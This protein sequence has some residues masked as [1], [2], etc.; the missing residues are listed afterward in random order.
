[1]IASLRGRI[2]AKDAEGLVL[3]CGGVGY[4]VA[5]S[6]SSL[7]RLGGEGSEAHVL[8]Y[9]HVGQDVLRLFGFADAAERRVFETLISINGVG[10]KLAL[11]VLSTFSPG[12]LAEVVGRGDIAALVKIPGVGKKKAERLLLDLKDKLA[13][14]TAAALG[15]RT[16]VHD[17][18]M[19]ALVNLGF[20]NTIADKAAR[21]AQEAHPSDTDLAV[22]V[23]TAL[24]AT[25][26]QGAS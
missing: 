26:G 5:M 4:G 10:P 14:T 6:I 13:I 15:M 20:T 1:V 18:L 8:T 23:R 25:R 21:A 19:S 7:A 12:E 3:E 9:T 2:V 24:R 17:D 11:A 16:T 22:L